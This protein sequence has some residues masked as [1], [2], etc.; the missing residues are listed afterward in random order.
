MNRISL[1][2]VFWLGFAP[3]LQADEAVE[4][5][6]FSTYKVFHRDSVGTGL[7]VEKGGA[8]FLVT[9]HHV[10]DRIPGPSCL[11][12]DRNKGKEGQYFRKDLKIQIR[13]AEGKPAWKKHE[14]LDIACLPLPKEFPVRAIPFTVLATKE[15]AAEL[16]TGD[17]VRSV[18]FPER[19]ESNGAGFPVV[20]QGIISN[21]PI[22]PIASHQHF[23]IDMTSFSGD[24][25]GPVMH[26]TLRRENGHP[27]V[28]GFVFAKRNITETV[29][30][31]RFVE[32]KITHP[33]HL[34][35]AIHAAFAL[36]LLP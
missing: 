15:D 25:G 32:R 34:S 9:A 4:T 10:L 5:L 12:V 11:L 20:R 29:K 21:F 2:C 22:T 27:I 19:E 6:L 1:F 16:H 13:S 31:S 14:K 7:V 28:L 30:E 3:F 23:L 35:Q 8:K 24:S 33:L 18:G 36:E 17:A 26:S